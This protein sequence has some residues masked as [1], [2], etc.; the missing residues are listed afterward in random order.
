MTRSIRAVLFDLY[1]TLLAFGDME[2]AWRAWGGL[3]YE[4]ML[5]AGGR[6]DRTT[7]PGL[8]EDVFS[9]A[10]PAPEVEGLTVHEARMMALAEEVG[11]TRFGP[12]DARAMATDGLALWQREV[13]LAPDCRQVLATLRER[14]YATG[15]V[16]NFDHPPHVEK[17]IEEH[18]LRPLLD[19]VV[20]SGA[21]GLKKPD[22]AIM[23]VALVALDVP[24]SE[25][26]FVG[27]S[28]EDVQAAQGAGMTAV[29]ISHDGDG[30]RLEGVSPDAWVTSL[31]EVV[32]W[33]E[34]RGG[35]DA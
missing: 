21:V 22:P 20:I 23:A 12:D 28:P 29:S 30:S 7:W 15:L 24:A 13:E 10:E 27:D 17:L 19:V 1:G 2:K 4:R 8:L 31:A 11:A 5:R 18:R 3:I 32:T 34:E 9:A 26:V 6:I 14:G 35:G 16:T 25:A 33:L